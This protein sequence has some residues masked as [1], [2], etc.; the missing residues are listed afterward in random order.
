[1]TADPSS[2]TPPRR[3][4]P[5]GA[6]AAYAVLAVATLFAL[7]PVYWMIVSALK[8]SAEIALLSPTLYPHHPT[9]A[10]LS[11]VLNDASLLRALGTS[12]L[13]AVATSVIV[14]VFG[15]AAAYITTHWSFRGTRSFMVL[16]LFTQL[17]PQS[18]VIVP[19]YLLWSRVDLV[20]S[21]SGLGLVYISIFLPVSVWMLTGYFQSI[22]KD[23][24][25]AALVDGASRL[26]ILFSIILP[27]AR[28]ALAAAAI[29]T[30]LACWSEFLLALVLLTGDTQTITIDLAGLIGQHSTDIGHLMAAST[31]ATVPPLVAF[32]ALQRFFVS[33]LTVGSVK[34]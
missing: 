19:V 15:S 1:M 30:A 3:R 20:G 25:E 4:L 17:L 11:S 2:L 10:Q 26:R 29:Y 34:G 7:A 13:L 31:V 5:K 33:G 21:R 16:T 9:L 18:A 28:P 23:L 8:S 6:W 32:F 12:A 22:P 27:V 24:T 14:V